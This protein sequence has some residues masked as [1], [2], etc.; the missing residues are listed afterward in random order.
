[1]THAELEHALLSM[2]EER[3]RAF[4]AKLLPEGTVL[5]GVRLP[6]LR[7]LAKTII[8]QNEHESVLSMLFESE[9]ACLEERM[10]QAFLIAL[11]PCSLEERLHRTE[12]FVPLISN[13]SVCDSFCAAFPVAKQNEEEIFLFVCT[14]GNSSAEFARRFAAVMLLDHFVSERWLAKTLS[15]LS[16]IS[17][18]GYYARMAVAWALS[19]CCVHDFSKTQERIFSGAFD[20]ETVRLAVSKCVDSRRISPEQKKVL[21]SKFSAL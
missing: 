7:T 13:W 20:R 8:S 18:E 1:M 17:T 14:F 5:L 6:K 15:V 9:S 10:L 11:S 2:A 19:V 21:R 3:Y 16:V 12:R 4:S